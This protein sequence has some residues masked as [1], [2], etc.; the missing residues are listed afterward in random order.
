MSKLHIMFWGFVGLFSVFGHAGWANP[1]SEVV[2]E[3]LKGEGIQVSSGAAAGYVPDR[4]CAECHADKAES[5]AEMGMA[6]SMYRPAKDKIIEDLDAMPYYHEPSQRHY[7]MEWRGDE[8]WFQRYG[9]TADGTKIDEFSV[10]VDWIMGS[11]NHV[12]VYLYQTA[13]GALFQLPLGWYT[14]TGKWAMAP[15]YESANHDGVLRDIHQRCIG[16][17]NAFGE[18]SERSGMKGH[19]GLYP[20]DLPEG[21]GCQRCHGPGSEHVYRAYSGEGEMEDLRSAIVNPGKLPRERLYSICYGCHMQS[22]VAVNSQLRLGRDHYS[23]R[24][25][26]DLRDFIMQLDI[27]E[28]EQSRE[29]RFEINHHPYR[30][31]QSTCFIQS[32]GELG[33]L[34]CHDPHVKIKPEQRAAHYRKACLSCHELDDDGLPAIEETEATHPQIAATDDCTTCHMPERRTEDVVEVW[35]TDHRIVRHIEPEKERMRAIKSVDPVVEGVFLQNPNSGVPKAEA[36]MLQLMAILDYS[37][38]KM[39]FAV[40]DLEKLLGQTQTPHFEPWLTLIE[41]Y[42]TNRNYAKARQ[43]AAATLKRAPDNPKVIN[44]VAVSLYATGEKAQAIEILKKAAKEMP[45]L[46]F[47]RLTLAKF[48][49]AEGKLDE[50]LHYA[51]SVVDQRPNQWQAWALIANLAQAKNDNERA[52]EAYLRTLEIRPVS[53]AIRKKT[54]S[55]LQAEGRQDDAARHQSR[56]KP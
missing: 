24:P 19:I 1:A 49:A 37:K 10:K 47:F 53:P 16:C 38:N 48:L 28:A 22:N 20:Q 35:M 36:S 7:T 46:I 5:F 55:L 21:I 43:I 39:D 12:R 40:R 9:K 34:S 45:D 54:V 31:E 51:E 52:L 25:G 3:F 27:K 23:F 44:A 2:I 32:K 15:G 56:L 42:I 26:E 13:D 18:L 8:M 6:R 33:C 50:A 17:H 41:A 11:G 14:Q 30:L 4:V 29:E